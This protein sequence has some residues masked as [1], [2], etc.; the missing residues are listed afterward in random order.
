MLPSTP[1]P[2]PPRHWAPLCFLPLSLSF[3]V[4]KAIPGDDTT[5]HLGQ[6]RTRG[7]QHT[8]SGVHGN[9]SSGVKPGEFSFSEPTRMTLHRIGWLFL[10]LITPSKMQTWEM[11][12]VGW[13]LLMGFYECRAPVC[14]SH[15]TTGRDHIHEATR[16]PSPACQQLIQ[17]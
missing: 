2:L 7:A 11:W 1:Q 14:A 17:M 8:W 10:F 15:Y 13:S 16:H 5:W 4:D 3:C 6:P 9:W 12:G